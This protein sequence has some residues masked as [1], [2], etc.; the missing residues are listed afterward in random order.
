VIRKLIYFPVAFALI[1]SVE[2]ISKFS[3][4]LAD[5]IYPSI[6]Y[7]DSA[8]AFLY[9]TIHHIFQGSIALLLMVLVSAFRHISLNDFGLNMN[10]WKYS[11]KRVA[12]FALIWWIIQLSVGFYMMS[13][14]TVGDLFSFE[15]TVNNYVGYFLFQ[16]LLSGTSEELLYRAL[17]LGLL[18]YF[19]KQAGFSKKTNIAFAIITSLSA[20]II[21]HISYTLFPF[22]ILSYNVLQLLTVVIFG[23]F[24][25]YLYFKTKSAF[26]PMLAHN[27]LNG[28]IVLSSLILFLVFKG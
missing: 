5:L 14:G 6:R 2:S 4:Y 20:F 24:Q 18:I 26:G 27:V 28:V 8:N 15:L 10:Q 21:G 16:I 7:L 9:I 23:S 11:V 3:F 17:L 22:S 25:I 1:F 13:S 19:G 12:Q